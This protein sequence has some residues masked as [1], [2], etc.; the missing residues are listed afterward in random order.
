MGIKQKLSIAFHPQTDSQIERQNNTIEAYL[1]IFVN[2][3]QNNWARLLLITEFAYNNV[4]NTSTVHTLF[5]F[6]Y[7]YHFYVSYKKDINSCFKSKSVN[8]LLTEL[9][10]LIIVYKENLHH[11]QKFQKQ[12]YDKAMKPKSYALDNK[13]LLN[14]KYIQIK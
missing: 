2:Y 1:K 5:K 6:N 3:K 8:E 10:K 9:Q 13:V 7:D 12:A 11:A 4:K 14:S